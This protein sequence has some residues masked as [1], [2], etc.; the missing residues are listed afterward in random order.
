MRAIEEAESL[1]AIEP[2]SVFE[3]DL[4]NTIIGL[5]NQLKI[6]QQAELVNRRLEQEALKQLKA[7]KKDAIELAVACDNAANTIDGLY[8]EESFHGSR[9]QVDKLRRLANKF[10]KIKEYE[11][12]K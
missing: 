11:E 8:E 4:Q 12:L 1:I 3:C 6:T 2:K 9:L 10:I 7:A 5:L